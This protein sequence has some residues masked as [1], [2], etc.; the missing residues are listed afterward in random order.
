MKKNISEIK[1]GESTPLVK[2][3][4][5]PPEREPRQ[6]KLEEKVL[7][8]RRVSKKTSGGNYISFSALV[9]VGDMNGKV[10][11]GIGRGLEVPQ[12]IKKGISYAKKHLITVPIYHA[13]IPHMVNVKFKAAH[14]ILKPAPEGAGLKVGSVV[15][16]ILSL[17][18]IS[19][20]SGKILRSRNQIT[21]AYVVMEAI[22]KLQE[23]K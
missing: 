18:G 20:A 21:N 10:G 15:R 8:I 13:T 12:A 16:S 22:K 3:S 4:A 11:I 5:T 17:A 1:K 14:L 7:L 23:K 19:N 6:E 2:K 9:A